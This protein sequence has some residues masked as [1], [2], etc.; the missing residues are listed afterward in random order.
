MSGIKWS[1]T[2]ITNGTYTVL[3]TDVAILCDTTAG[4]ITLNLPA[5]SGRTG[6]FY[7][8]HRKAGTTNSI[9]IDPN[10]AETIN[11]ATTLTVSTTAHSDVYIFTDGTSWYSKI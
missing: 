6:K 2:T 1:V 3:D 10:A 9:T 8:I 7:I 4:T 11:G 5:A